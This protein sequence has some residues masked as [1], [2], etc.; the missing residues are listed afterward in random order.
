LFRNPEKE[1]G[2]YPSQARPNASGPPKEKSTKLSKMLEKIAINTFEEV[3][4]NFCP[5]ASS[6]S[7]TDV[8]HNGLRN[9]MNLPTRR[10]DPFL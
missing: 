6:T 4:P 10:P 2:L 9:P 1:A 3:L 7:P 8:C 5:A